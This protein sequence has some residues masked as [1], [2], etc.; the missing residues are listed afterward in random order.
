MCVAVASPHLSDCRAQ[1]F[2]KIT[3][4]IPLKLVKPSSAFT[5]ESEAAANQIFC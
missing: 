3:Q 4:T 5:P 1:I 2:K